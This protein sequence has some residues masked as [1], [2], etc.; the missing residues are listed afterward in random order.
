MTDTEIVDW[1]N[2]NDIEWNPKEPIKGGPVL[3][4]WYADADSI[5]I[6]GLSLRESVRRAND[7]SS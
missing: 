4:V 3:V 1:L 7:R 6:E 2:E 5:V